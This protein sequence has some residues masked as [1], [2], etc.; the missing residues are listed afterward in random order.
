[1]EQ[2]WL[3][4]DMHTHSGA[5]AKRKHSENVWPMSAK[6]FVDTLYD[7]GNKVFSVTDHNS[8]DAKFYDEMDQ[9]IVD[10]H[11]QMK[12]INGV[13]FDTYIDDN[14][15][16]QICI[17]FEDHVERTELEAIVDNLYDHD[18]KPRFDKILNCLASL[19]CKLIVIPH[20]DK[21][22]KRRVNANHDK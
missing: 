11:L 2:E 7:Y 6:E 8:F 1:M 21:Q 4:I 15:F 22:G 12:L 3:L 5:S 17:Y 9:F 10:N 14:N 13:E 20:G 16:I 18:E 19:N